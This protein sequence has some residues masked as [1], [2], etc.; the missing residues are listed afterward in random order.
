MNDIAQR[1]REYAREI[2]VPLFELCEQE[3][4]KVVSDD[5]VTKYTFAD[6]SVIML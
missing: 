2:K 5:Y 3:A 6:G 1:I 4:V